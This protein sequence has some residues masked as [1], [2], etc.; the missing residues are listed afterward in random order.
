MEIRIGSCSIHVAVVTKQVCCSPKKFYATLLLFFLCIFYNLLHMLLV[1]LNVIS[2]IN[3]IYIMKTV[4]RKL[5]FGH[6]LKSSIHFVFCT[7]ENSRFFIPR[8]KQCGSSKGIRTI[9]IKR[10]PISTG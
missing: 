1:L 8:E 3:Q 10:M 7:F 9:R 5:H 4:I 6:K 2:M